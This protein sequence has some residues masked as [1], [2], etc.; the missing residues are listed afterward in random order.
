MKTYEPKQ[1]HQDFKNDITNVLKKYG[2]KLSAMEVLAISS[3]IVG[4]IVAMQDQRKITSDMA[5]EVVAANIEIGNKAA[6]QEIQNPIG[7]A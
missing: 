6:L 4:M 1:I 2:D 7:S 5:M 3:Q